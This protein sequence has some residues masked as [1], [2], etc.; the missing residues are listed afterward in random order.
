MSEVSADSFAIDVVV[1]K[2]GTRYFATTYLGDINFRGKTSTDPIL[3]VQSLLMTLADPNGDGPIA[4]T[5]AIEGKSLRDMT[6]S[7]KEL[8]SAS[9]PP[10]T[11]A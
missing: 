5:L 3:A 8:R 11:A 6:T 1:G 7:A 9:P 10:D 4:V 2:F